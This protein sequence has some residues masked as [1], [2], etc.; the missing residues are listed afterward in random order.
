[1]KPVSRN[2]F[3]AHSLASVS[4]TAA[5]LLGMGGSA[6]AVDYTYGS[7]TENFTITASDQA[8]GRESA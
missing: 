8:R 1:M 2:R 6:R 4:I 5:A 3:L 7:I